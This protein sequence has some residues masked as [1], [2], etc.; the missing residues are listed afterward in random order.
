VQIA[1]KNKKEK[2]K[3]T[4]RNH[5]LKRE[6]EV[7]KAGE[8]SFMKRGGELNSQTLQGKIAPEKERKKPYV[9]KRFEEWV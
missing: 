8:L 4:G 9:L 5:K 2:E 7:T 6:E 1:R 3:K